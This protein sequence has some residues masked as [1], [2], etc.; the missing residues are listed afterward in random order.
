MTASSAIL[1]FI[2]SV[3]IAAVGGYFTYS[4][5]ERQIDLN[6]TPSERD[7]NTKDQANKVLELEAD[8]PG[9]FGAKT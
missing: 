2:S 3:L 6:R 7:S 4:Y 9:A 8:I 5:N 1:S